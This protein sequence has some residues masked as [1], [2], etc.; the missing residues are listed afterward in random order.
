MILSV[1]IVY[2]ALALLSTLT[3]IGMVTSIGTH[4]IY[5]PRDCGACGEFKKLTNEFERDVINAAT[6]GDPNII[7][8]LIEQYTSD[9]RAIDFSQ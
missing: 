3:I 2:C 9:V 1:K 8:G 4:Q 6:I 7:L 5:A